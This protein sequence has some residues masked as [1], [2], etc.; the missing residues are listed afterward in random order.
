MHRMPDLSSSAAFE[1]PHP[2]MDHVGFGRASRARPE[3]HA[4]RWKLASEAAIVDSS[5][6]SGVSFPYPDRIAS[7]F[8]APLGKI[9]DNLRSAG[10]RARPPSCPAAPT[11]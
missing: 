11:G 1:E 7:E 9:R 3:A 8:F 10:G 5:Y 2:Q 4:A 6:G